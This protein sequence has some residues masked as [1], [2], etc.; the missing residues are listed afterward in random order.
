MRVFGIIAGAGLFAA[1]LAPVRLRG[2]Y[3]ALFGVACGF[4][5][6]VAGVLLQA[7][8]PGVI[9]TI[10]LGAAACAAVGLVTLAALRRSQSRQ[11]SALSDQQQQES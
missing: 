3:L 5:P 8:L 11:Q 2:T 9:W 4:S 7:E 10:Q 6:I 1:E